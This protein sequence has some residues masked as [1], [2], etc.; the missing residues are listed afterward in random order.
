MTDSPGR[1]PRRAKLTFAITPIRLGGGGRLGNARDLTVASAKARATVRDSCN[2]RGWPPRICSDSD[3]AHVPRSWVQGTAMHG[4]LAMHCMAMSERAGR[5]AI[6][7][8]W[9]ADH[10]LAGGTRWRV[11][12]MLQ[13]TEWLGA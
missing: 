8:L 4:L 9:Q 7:S 12:C 13:Y 2:N 3:V 10:P 5:P 11:G 6:L 1:V